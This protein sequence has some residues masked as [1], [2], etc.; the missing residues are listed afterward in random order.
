MS[1]IQWYLLSQ[2]R[3]RLRIE[4]GDIAVK[5][6]GLRVQ[7]VAPEQPAGVGPPTAFAGSVG[8]AVLVA[9]LVMDAMGGHPEDGSALKSERGAGGHD[10]L[11]PLGNLVAAMGEQAVIAH[12][13]AEIDGYDVE[14]QHHH[15][16][17]PTEKEECGQGAEMKCDDHGERKP[18]DAGADG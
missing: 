13:D 16:A 14:R 1:G 17:L 15:Q 8:V 11:K 5:N 6:L 12:A 2:T 18:V 10:V 3:K 7:G 4:V 9:E